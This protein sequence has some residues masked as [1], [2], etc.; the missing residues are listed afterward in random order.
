MTIFGLPAFFRSPAQPTQTIQCIDGA[1]KKGIPFTTIEYIPKGDFKSTDKNGFIDVQLVPEDTLIISSIGYKSLKIPAEELLNKN[2]VSLPENYQLQNEVIVGHLK[3]TEIKVNDSKA[4]FSFTANF[5]TQKCIATEI[6]IPVDIKRLR[7]N[8]VKIR[9]RK[10][11]H[12]NI[13]PV[14]LHIYKVDQNG[15]PSEIEVLKKDIVLPEMEINKTYLE[16]KLDDQTIIMMRNIDSSFYVGIEFLDYSHSEIFD[17]PE[18]KISQKAGRQNTVFKN[19]IANRP[20]FNK[21]WL[22]ISDEDVSVSK[23]IKAIHPYNMI[24]TVTVSVIE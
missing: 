3:E 15:L 6:T 13:N 4:D 19:F 18:I 9:I 16:F 10:T 17:S 7:L 24:V 20:E 22:Y 23:S 12:K 2:V 21:K 5:K 11:A 8:A 1:T 14:R